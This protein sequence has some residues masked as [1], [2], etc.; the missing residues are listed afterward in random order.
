MFT[1][2]VQQPGGAAVE[3]SPVEESCRFTTAA[4]GGYGSCAFTLEGDQRRLLPYLSSITVMYGSA[5]AWQGRVED[6]EFA[7]AGEPA[8]TAVSCFGFQRLLA[9]VSV[10]RIWSKRDPSW[11]DMPGS[12]VPVSGWTLVRAALEEAFGAFDLANPTRIG[13]EFRGNGTGLTSGQ[14]RYVIYTPQSGLTL[15]TI[16]GTLAFSLP[17]GMAV[18]IWTEAGDVATY[19]AAGAVSAALSSAANIGLGLV[20]P[21]AGTLTPSAAQYAQLYDLRILGTSLAEDTSGGFY[22]GTILRDLIALIPGLNIGLIEAGSDFT[23]PSVERSVR[24]TCLSVVQEI[25]GFYSREW[26]VW[27]NGR[28][29]WKTPNLDEP[30]W[31]IPLEK[32]LPGTRFEGSVDTLART[33]YVLYSLAFDSSISGEQSSVATDQRN[34]LVRTS[35]TK[36]AMVQAPTIMTDNTASQYAATVSAEQQFPPVTGTIV[37]PARAL[38]KSAIGPAMPAALIR[39][40]SN[41]YLPD[42]PQLGSALARAGRDGQTLFHIIGTELDMEAETITLELEGQGRQLDVIT[43]RLAAA[44]RVLTG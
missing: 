29:D 12:T 28:F 22:G 9:D 7:P 40:G 26:A 13:V 39:A 38:I 30:Q 16:I 3:V 5:V 42:V 19:T 20:N 23:V 37:L 32:M 8:T 17:A 44:T 2:V 25:A 15:Q 36:D 21:T 24:D 11:K 43:A 35:Q 27:D 34:P 1:I 4:V 41:V 18:K 6:V 33:V 14:G 31:I 10:R